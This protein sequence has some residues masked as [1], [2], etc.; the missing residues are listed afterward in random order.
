MKIIIT[1]KNI[2]HSPSIEMGRPGLYKIRES[3][4]DIT[5]GYDSISS[6]DRTRRFLQNC[7]Q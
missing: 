3:E 7:E 2:F 5:Q 6:D 4:G 1:K